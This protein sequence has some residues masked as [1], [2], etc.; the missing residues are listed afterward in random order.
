MIAAK[1]ALMITI[2]S[3]IFNKSKTININHNVMLKNLLYLSV[4]ISIISACGS[5]DLLTNLSD[6]EWKV[7]SIRGKDINPGNQPKNFPTL[8]FG[9]NNKLFGSTGCNRFIGSFK[10][11]KNNISLEPGAVTKMYCQDSPEE[12]FL[13]AIK[14]VKEFKLE[15]N[16]LTL[17][18]RSE[19]IMTLIP[20]KK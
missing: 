8:N 20:L 16:T 1:I 12:A 15:G 3:I 5:P 19:K 13:S 2:F 11:D 17:L 4:M 9:N 10:A 14:L 7:I 6:N 18:N